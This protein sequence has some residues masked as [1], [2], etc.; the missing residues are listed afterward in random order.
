MCDVQISHQVIHYEEHADGWN[1]AQATRG[2]TVLDLSPKNRDLSLVAFEAF[3]GASQFCR[4]Y[5]HQDC[6]VDGRDYEGPPHFGG[7][8]PILPFQL[9]K[10]PLH[11]HLWREVLLSLICLVLAGVGRAVQVRGVRRWSVL[12]E[13]DQGTKTLIQD[14]KRG[15]TG[16]CIAEMEE[17][18]VLLMGSFASPRKRRPA[19]D[20]ATS[21]E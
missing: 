16:R 21:G 12:S 9:L 6:P 8:T 5:H 17:L 4:R 1:L 10:R 19:G 14:G 11:S 3:S 7:L 15:E 2:P 13:S 18:K 20:G